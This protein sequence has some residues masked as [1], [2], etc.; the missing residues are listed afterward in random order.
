MGKSNKFSLATKSHSSTRVNPYD[1]ITSNALNVTCPDRQIILPKLRS[2]GVE[3]VFIELYSFFIFII[4]L[5]TQYLNLYRSVWWLP[6]ARS[7]INLHLIDLDV[8]QFSIIFIGQTSLIT[9]LK[10]LLSRAN[11]S[12]AL[13]LTH[14][15]SPISSSSSSSL[16]S[17]ETHHNNSNNYRDSNT[18]NSKHALSLS[19]ADQSTLATIV[20]ATTS[21]TCIYY[22][23]KCAYRIWHNF[24]FN[25][26]LCILYPIVSIIHLKLPIRDSCL[27]SNQSISIYN[28]VV[29]I[30]LNSNHIIHVVESCRKTGKLNL[31]FLTLS[32]TLFS[33]HI[34]FDDDKL[35]HSCSNQPDEIRDE[36][37]KLK[38]VFN[39]RLTFVLIKSI[40]LAYYSSFVPICFAQS[41]LY[42]DHTWTVKHVVITW[43]SSLIMLVSHTFTP[44]FYDILHRSAYHFGKWHKLESRNTLVPCINWSENVIYPQGKCDS[45]ILRPIHLL[46]IPNLNPNYN[47][48]IGVVVKHYRGYFRS[49]SVSNCAQ[50]G[51]SSHFHYYIVFSNPKI[52]YAAALTLLGALL[53]GQ[54]YLLLVSTEW[55][56]LIA[57]SIMMLINVHSIFRL[58]KSL[59]VIT[60]IY[61]EKH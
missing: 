6:K 39:E 20:T 24:G 1:K 55:Y 44:Y 18:N 58:V 61:K 21:W 54:M 11:V 30:A 48:K 49:E 31:S 7:P 26:L 57:L 42:Y 13:N 41:F 46:K 12:I 28:Q 23:S 8:S 10:A 56:K 40:L 29:S 9:L 33:Y 22:L 37:G 16:T 50:P 25:G 60:K 3:Y 38:A 2:N 36:V 14:H 35:C 45:K 53:T 17:S 4:A 27:E 5:G 52:G 15:Y 47:R 51:V 43:F 59:T 19:Q 32:I 34:K